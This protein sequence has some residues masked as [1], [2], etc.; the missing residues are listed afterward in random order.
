MTP[1]LILIAAILLPGSGQV[2]NRQPLRGLTFVFFIL[3][4]GALTMITAPPEA[5]AIGRFAGGLFIWALSIPDA[6][7]VAKL[8]AALKPPQSAAQTARP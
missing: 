7:R 1:H 4:F 6:Y 8:R 3:L 2:L 5:S